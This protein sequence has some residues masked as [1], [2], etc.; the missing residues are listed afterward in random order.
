M[1]LNSRK[2][3]KNPNH[4]KNTKS[5]S[6]RPYNHNNNYNKGYNNYNNNLAQFNNSTYNNR[7]TNLHNNMTNQPSTAFYV[8][9]LPNNIAMG[10]TQFKKAMS[11][12]P[13][14]KLHPMLSILNKDNELLHNRQTEPNKQQLNFNIERTNKYLTKLSH[15]L[16][17]NN[18]ESTKKM[19]EEIDKWNKKWLTTHDSLP[20][21]KK[22]TDNESDKVYYNK[23]NE[24]KKNV[25]PKSFC[26][27]NSDDN[28]FNYIANCIK[29]INSNNTICFSFDIEAFEKDNK[30]ITEIGISIYD[31][32]DNLHNSFNPIIRSFHLII[33][34]SL[35]LINKNWVCDMKQCFILGESLVMNLENCVKFIQ[36]LINFYL[37]PMKD[38]IGDKSWNR[39]FVGHNIEGDFKWLKSMNIKLPENLSYLEDGNIIDLEKENKPIYVMDTFKIYKYLYSN[40]GG[41]LGKLLRLFSLPHAF[42][43][44]AG[45]DSYYTLKLLFFMCDI[46]T[47]EKARLDSFSLIQTRAKEFLLR[48]KEENKIIPMSY[49]LIV[50]PKSMNKR[51]D[52]VPQTE[53]GGARYIEDYDQIDTFL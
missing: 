44:N 18:T 41:S 7:R 29:L 50:N 35:N 25:I 51:K 43:H 6:T 10:I 12:L 31:P 4:T 34:E 28:R 38:E 14:L 46:N 21:L 11:N 20:D 45:N 33:S 2:F 16:V 36:D 32:R 39:S 19:N 8:R 13:N 42:L 53:F 3:L 1:S 48:A 30:I 40:E 9:N 47:R 5:Y 49:G 27:P 24:I 37:V 22:K 15:I 23:L 17:E 26:S 52:L